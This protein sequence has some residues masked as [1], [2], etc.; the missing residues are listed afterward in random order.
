MKESI[1]A[2]KRT[3]AR[4]AALIAEMQNTINSYQRVN[5]NLM[6]DYVDKKMRSEQAVKLL[7]GEDV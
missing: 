6:H 1:P 5:S 4:Q 2:L 7:N 3:I